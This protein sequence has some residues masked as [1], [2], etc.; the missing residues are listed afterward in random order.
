MLHLWEGKE[1]V[2][3]CYLF[4]YIII[5]VDFFLFILYSF[6]F[7]IAIFG[8]TMQPLLHPLFFFS[9]SLHTIHSVPNTSV[10]VLG[11]ENHYLPR[12]MS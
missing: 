3:L 6:V 12:K 7:A 11:G 8:K 5:V 4:I 9:P 10:K 2:E 1:W